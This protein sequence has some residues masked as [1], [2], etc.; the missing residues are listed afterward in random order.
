MTS[1]MVTSSTH[2]WEDSKTYRRAH[3]EWFSP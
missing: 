2:G 1:G 3:V